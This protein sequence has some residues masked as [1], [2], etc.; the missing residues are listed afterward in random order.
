M[1]NKK[2]EP[3]VHIGT[4]GFSYSHWKNNFYP[5]GLKPNRWLNY[6]SDVFP[7]VE[8]NTTFY[9]SPR[10]VTVQNWYDQVPPNFLFAVKAHRYITHQKRLNECQES[11][12]FFYKSIEN[13]KSKIGPILFQLPP[14]FQK[15][16]ERLIE[17]ISTLKKDYR[18]T[19][20]FRH[21]TWFTDEIYELLSKN[22]IALCITDLNGK[23]TPEVVTTDFTY[24]RL[25]GPHKAY[26]GS[27]GIAKL[28]KWKTK[29]EKWALN[30]S[31]YCYFDNDEKGYAIQDAK[32]LLDFFPK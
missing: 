7:T 22:H 5:D 12:D 10:V 19:F 4:S 11:V 31:V 13:F 2:K 25:H 20:E 28:K 21:E 30:A 18:Y 26:Q 32:Y 27:Y 17:F 16:K 1:K 14:S 15:N 23:Q 9:H 8:M 6:Y 24:M 3:T 29:I